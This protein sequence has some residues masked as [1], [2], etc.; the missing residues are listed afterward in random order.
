[1]KKLVFVLSLYAVA[2]CVLLSGCSK[3][4]KAATQSGG[5]TNSSAASAESDNPAEMK[6]K[7]AVGK[8]YLMRMEFTQATETQLPNQPQPTKLEV[9]LA[10]DFNMSA[11]KDLDSGGKEPEMEFENETMDISQGGHSVSSFD[12]TQSSADDTNN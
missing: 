12:S 11:L 4:K 8:K 5:S 6:I 10:Q 9:K 1:M 7:W 2:G 3:S